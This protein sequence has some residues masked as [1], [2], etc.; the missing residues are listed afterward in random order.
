MNLN[1]ELK[2]YF[3]NGRRGK[4]QSNKKPTNIYK[5]KK[6]NKQTNKQTTTNKQTKSRYGGKLAHSADS[7]V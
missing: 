5:S 7:S 4:K 3:W 1:F 2:I 6:T